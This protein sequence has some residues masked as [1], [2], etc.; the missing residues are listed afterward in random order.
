MV[1]ATIILYAM[2]PISEHE[3]ILEKAAMAY[4]KVLSKV[5][6]CCNEEV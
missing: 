2:I 4:F 1:T 6:K 3:R 5:L